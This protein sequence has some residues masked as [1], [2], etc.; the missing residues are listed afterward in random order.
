MTWAETGGATPAREQTDQ[1]A[2]MWFGLNECAIST[3]EHHGIYHDGAR[4]PAYVVNALE[5]QGNFRLPVQRQFSIFQIQGGDGEIRI[6]PVMAAAQAAGLLK[7]DGDSALYVVTCFSD[8]DKLLSLGR[9]QRLHGAA[10]EE[11]DRAVRRSSCFSDRDKLLS[12]VKKEE[13]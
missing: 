10:G 3:K 11:D 1:A 5:R 2:R 12:L 8:R 9:A 6:M 4:C 7:E 13:G